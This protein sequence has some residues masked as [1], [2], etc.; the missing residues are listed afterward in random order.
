[1]EL[2]APSTG[3]EETKEQQPYAII[4]IIIMRISISLSLITIDN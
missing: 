1:M 3:Y 2:Q 4:I